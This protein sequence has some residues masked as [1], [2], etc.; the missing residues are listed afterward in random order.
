MILRMLAIDA[1][2]VRLGLVRRA[3]V[4]VNDKIVANDYI[5]VVSHNN[6][7]SL[8]FIISRFINQLNNEHH[9][10]LATVMV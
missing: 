10:E 1:L 2:L 5:F 4:V 6:D 7:V 3:I 9:S 8:S